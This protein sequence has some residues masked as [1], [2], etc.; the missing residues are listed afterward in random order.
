MGV[1]VWAHRIGN[2][3]RKPES[4]FGF[5][6]R[7]SG[8]DDLIASMSKSGLRG[9]VESL[10]I[11]AHGD[12]SGLVQLDRNL[13]PTALPSFDREFTN[14]KPYFEPSAGSKLIFMSC[15]AGLEKD[16][17]RLLCGISARL[18][19]VHVSGFEVNGSTVAEGMP[20]EP[21]SLTDGIGLM[22]GGPAKLMKGKPVLDEYSI[23]SKWA[24]NGYITR[25][26][27]R[28]QLQRKGLKCAWS[29]CPGHAKPTD[30]C[31]PAT[32]GMQGARAYPG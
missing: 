11:V 22:N 9:R 18:A 6:I 20:M 21:G 27:A 30:R 8:L 13:T 29:L 5:T 23:F 17:D 7:F 15:L 25:I 4:G 19:N 2:F 32:K 31:V 28:E 26:P 12:E 3:V 1:R 16:G 24:F 14:L 10:V